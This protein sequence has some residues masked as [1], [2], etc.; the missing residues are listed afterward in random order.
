MNHFLASSACFAVTLHLNSETP[1]SHNPP[2]IYLIVQFQHALQLF[3]NYSSIL[4]IGK[5]YQLE[6][7]AHV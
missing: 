2:F 3:Q 7:S 4:P 6:Y 5:S 1:A